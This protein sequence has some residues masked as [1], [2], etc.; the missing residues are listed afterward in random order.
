MSKTIN[1]SIKR[2]INNI[3]EFKM[4]YLLLMGEAGKRVYKGSL[5][6][7]FMLKHM[8]ELRGYYY[9]WTCSLDGIRKY[10]TKL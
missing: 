6:E 10:G 2:V 4:E 9:L 1:Y 5:E 8:L 7:C 3:K